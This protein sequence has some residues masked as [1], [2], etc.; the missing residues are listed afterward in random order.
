MPPE[1]TTTGSPPFPQGRLW[2]GACAG[3]VAWGLQG[4]FCAAIS[5]GM[6]KAAY[7]RIEDV[8]ETGTHTWLIVI[9]VVLLCVTLAGAMV[10]LSNW[11]KLTNNARLVH[12][13]ATGREQ[14][15]ALVGVFVNVVFALGIVW[16]LLAVLIVNMCVRA[17]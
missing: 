16:S 11:R 5:A 17:R 6:C 15:M 4:A 13:E 12:A 14:Y 8:R 1:A 7:S 3:A 2:F 10:A 9:T